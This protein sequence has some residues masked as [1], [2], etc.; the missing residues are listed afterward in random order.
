MYFVGG[1]RS[2][3]GHVWLF[4]LR[5]S[6]CA[7]WHL[8]GLL[9]DVLLLCLEELLLLLLKLLL[10]LLQETLLL[11][12]CFLLHCDLL[13]NIVLLLRIVA[14]CV[15]TALNRNVLVPDQRYWLFYLLFRLSDLDYLWMVLRL[16][17]LLRVRMRCVRWEVLPVVIPDLESVLLRARGY[18]L[19]A[20]LLLVRICVFHQWDSSLILRRSNRLLLLVVIRN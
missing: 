8:C 19:V 10:L 12:Q 1:L 7:A 16:Q 20:L 18:D 6:Y 13:Q 15:L 9:G 3:L 11:F 14:L 4:I 2:S 17:R 5:L